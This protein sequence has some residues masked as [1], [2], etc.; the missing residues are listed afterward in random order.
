MERLRAGSLAH[1]RIGRAT[2][3]LVTTDS[4]RR[5]LLIGLIV[6]ALLLFVQG[7]GVQVAHLPGR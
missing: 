4:I 2:G 5:V 7:M 6:V 3:R 1:R